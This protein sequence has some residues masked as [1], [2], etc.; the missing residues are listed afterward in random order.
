MLFVCLFFCSQFVALTQPLNALAFVFDGVNYGVSDFH[1]SA[2]SMAS[3][4]FTILFQGDFFSCFLLLLLF[5]TLLDFFYNYYY[6]NLHCET[7]GVGGY[8]EHLVLVC[9]VIK[10]WVYRHLGCSIF[11]YELAYISWLFQV[12]LKHRSTCL[13]AWENKKKIH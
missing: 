12:N 13:C 3:I 5:F 9:I 11:L 10:S 2:Y 1:Y 4:F 7:S 8:S 6:F